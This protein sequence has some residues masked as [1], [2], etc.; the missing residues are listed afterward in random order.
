MFAIYWRSS[1]NIL[2]GHGHASSH[3]LFI[4]FFFGPVGL[5]TFGSSLFLLGDLE[6]TFDQTRNYYHRETIDGKPYF[7]S[8]FASTN[9]CFLGHNSYKY[10]F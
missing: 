10:T 9:P 6:V 2:F 7:Q 4:C 5:P 1:L 8:N 3:F